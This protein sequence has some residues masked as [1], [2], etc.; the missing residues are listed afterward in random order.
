VA[1]HSA[2]KEISLKN[3]IAATLRP[4]KRALQSLKVASFHKMPEWQQRVAST[5]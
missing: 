1:H 3:I 5:S 4:V 2:L